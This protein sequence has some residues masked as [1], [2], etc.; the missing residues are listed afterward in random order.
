MYVVKILIG[1]GGEL[2]EGKTGTSGT[3]AGWM[4]WTRNVG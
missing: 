1:Y 2:L 4:A 3:P